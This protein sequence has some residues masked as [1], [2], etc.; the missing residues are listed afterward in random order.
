MFALSKTFYTN[1][2]TQVNTLDTAPGSDA[3]SLYNNSLW[4]QWVGRT[5]NNTAFKYDFGQEVPVNLLVLY[6]H[7]VNKTST[8]CLELRDANNVILYNE[9]WIAGTLDNGFGLMPSGVTGFGG[10]YNNVNLVEPYNNLVKLIPTQ[11][12]RHARITIIHLDAPPEIG[13]LGIGDA[14]IPSVCDITSLKVDYQTQGSQSRSIAGS[15]YGNPA[16]SFR[17][18]TLT[19]KL[20]SFI[21]LQKFIEAIIDRNTSKLMFFTGI[22][23]TD[24]QITPDLAAFKRVITMLCF[25]EKENYPKYELGPNR[26]SEI[27]LTFVE[28]L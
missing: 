26:S 19:A 9:C 28:A 21:D 24:S 14:F 22:A 10:Y 15:F 27:R 6:N 16:V 20:F 23:V 4:Q 11:Y 5:S 18:V 3:R 12:A 1:K 8:L 25:F 2:N 7:N 17:R 13:F